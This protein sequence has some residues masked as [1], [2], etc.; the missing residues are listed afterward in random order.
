MTMIDSQAHYEARR[1]ARVDL[2]RQ[3]V[4]NSEFYDCLFERCALAETTFRHCRFVGCVFR[5]CDLSLA[6]VPQCAFTETR[7]ESSKLIG[8]DWTRAHWPDTRLGDPLGFSECVLSHATFIGL[9]LPRLQMIDCVALDV[10]FREA[11]LAGAAF[12][13]TDLAESLFL[14]TN[15]TGADLSRARNYH[16]DP[17]QNTLTGA[18]FA[19]PEAM[20]LL[21]SMDIELLEA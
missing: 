21:A 15:L 5:A 12:G 11:D 1:F 9:V 13:G 20:S 17:C 7:F 16:I 8:I 10:D 14:A 2:V 18:K 19:L 3:T 4:V 6:Q